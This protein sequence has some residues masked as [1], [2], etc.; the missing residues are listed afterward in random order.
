MDYP[1]ERNQHGHAFQLSKH[2]TL[3]K[4]EDEESTFQEEN[5]NEELVEGKSNFEDQ[6]QYQELG[7]VKSN[8]V[9]LDEETAS[10]EESAAREFNVEIGVLALDGV[11]AP[12]DVALLRRFG[13]EAEEASTV[14]ETPETAGK[15]ELLELRKE[16][17]DEQADVQ[18]QSLRLIHE[19]I[20]TP[21]STLAGI[22]VEVRK[23]ELRRRGIQEAQI[24]ELLQ[25][26][27]QDE[28]GQR[29]LEKCDIKFGMGYKDRAKKIKFK[30]LVD[31]H[32][33]MAL[34]L[35]RWCRA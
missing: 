26:F 12:E 21:K 33:F 8:I 17:G 28:D 11:V 29:M 32:E 18:R 3:V 4:V 13:Y 19:L 7:E 15:A 25:P 34:K 10:E 1:F 16:V 9:R 24:H 14:A 22:L 5:Q 20:A 2:L 35:Q 27:E 30:T 31:I 6:Y 23:F